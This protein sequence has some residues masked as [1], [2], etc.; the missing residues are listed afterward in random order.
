MWDTQEIFSKGQG[1]EESSWT[2]CHCSV[3]KKGLAISSDPSTGLRTVIVGPRRTVKPRVRMW[4]SG[5]VGKGQRSLG[6]H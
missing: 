6:C 1:R 3:G 4:G 2:N 5:T